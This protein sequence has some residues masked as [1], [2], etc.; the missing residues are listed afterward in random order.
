MRIEGHRTSI[1][2]EPEFWDALAVIAARE[3]LTMSDLI[4]RIDRERSERD[5]GQPLASAARIFALRRKQ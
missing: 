4:A 2:L 1:A 3:G 5:P